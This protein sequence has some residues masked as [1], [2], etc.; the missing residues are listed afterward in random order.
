MRD[1]RIQNNGQ[2]LDYT[3]ENRRFRTN[4]A[5]NAETGARPRAPASVFRGPLIDHDGYSL[6]LEH[7][8]EIATGERCYWLMWYDANGWPTI[9]LSG[10]LDRS[11][12]P[13]MAGRLASFVR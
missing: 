11:E 2:R 13:T 12:I 7:V 5:M 10:V 4:V 9:P 1:H 8:I 6:W 3:C